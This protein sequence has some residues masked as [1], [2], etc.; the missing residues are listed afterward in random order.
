MPSS[1]LDKLQ[2]YIERNF[3]YDFI[4]LEKA[5]DRV[6]MELIWWVLGR[7]KVP[8][9]YVDFIKDMYEGQQVF[10]QQAGCLV[11]SQKQQD[12]IKGQP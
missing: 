4:D 8:Q 11:N 12:Y 1:Y 6:F 9:C 2:K 10:A 3:A 5:Y 7:K